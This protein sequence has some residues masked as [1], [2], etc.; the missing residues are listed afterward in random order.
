MATKKFALAKSYTPDLPWCQDE[1]DKLGP[2]IM[3]HVMGQETFRRKWAQKWFENFNFVYGNQS[4]KWSQRYDFAVDVDFLRRESPLAQKAQTNIART[5]LEA[6]AAL[7]YADLPSWEADTADE[8]SQK[9]KRFKVIAQKVLQAYMTRLNMDK[10]FHSAALIYTA[11]GQVGA[12]VDWD[13]KGGRLVTVPQWKKNRAPVYSTSMSK[14]PYL[15][16]LL[17][18]VQQTVDSAGEPYFEDRWEP[19]LDGKGRQ[20]QKQVFAGD[21]SVKM[22]TP[23]EYERE[24]GSSGM[25]KTKYVRQIRLMDYDEWLTEYS[26]VN[27]K[28]KHFNEVQ[29]TLQDQ[30]MHTFAVRHFLRLQFTTPPSL[31]DMQRRTESVMKGAFLKAKV[32]VIEHFDRPNEEM[33]PTGRRVIVTNGKCTHITEP[34]YRTNKLDGWHPFLEA[35]WM[36]IAPSSV[37]TGPLNDVIAKNRETNV[38]DSY[39]ATALRRSLG[40]TLLLKTGAGFDA[41]KFSGEPAQ[42]MEAGDIDGARWLDSPNPIPS[43]L[44]ALK[45]MDK[46]EIYE[47]SGA[48]DA[49]RGDR[50][51]GASSGYML[52]QLEERE[53][54]RLTPAKKSFEYFVAGIGEKALAC[55]KQNALELDED[56]MGYL[57]RSAAGEFQIQDIIAFLSTPMDYGI[58]ITVKQE[59]MASKSKASMQATM[60]ELAKGPLQQ[61]LQNDAGVLDN[62]LKYFDAEN[63]RDKSATHRD[64]SNRENEIFS[65]M[66]R[67]GPDAEGLRVPKV[68]YED[69]DDIHLE[70]HA[71]Y[72]LKNSDELLNNEPL[73]QQLVLHLE[74]HRIQKQ[75]KAGE[76]LPGT[77]QQVPAMMAQ[78][79]AE[80]PPTVGTIY[81][82]TQQQA[83]IKQQKMQQAETDKAIAKQGAQGGGLKAPTA[84]GSPA[85]VGSKGPPQVNPSTP[86][87]NTPQAA[88]VGGP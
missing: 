66:A 55:L 26:E 47:V 67:L 13:H 40:S 54:K 60:Q 74:T 4:I 75:E 1:P 37:A 32:L 86:S 23:F 46:D 39:I 27:G 9:G 15:D 38:K 45:T 77:T 20:I 24:P 8:S 78:A 29:P 22:L 18:T 87:Q 33:W 5:V 53:Q 21:V 68:L 73:L 25:H 85:P 28:T 70:A 30:V 59:S 31:L 63:L 61:R 69:D 62:Y 84:P 72:L 83:Q 41:Q 80:K 82:N 56:V 49:L 58:D 51:K 2:A 50:S 35:Q 16:G 11:Y 52:K 14:N 76:V 7:I 65:D 79:R 71:D 12:R 17:E 42:V 81:Q 48:Q 44:S 36:T 43:V 6:L 88:S 57:M 64:R 3:E 19:V 34:Q 10:E